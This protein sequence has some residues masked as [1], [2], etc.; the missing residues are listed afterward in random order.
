MPVLWTL[1]IVPRQKEIR[2]LDK[3][4]TQKLLVAAIFKNLGKKRDL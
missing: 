4:V 2:F 3:G 1:A